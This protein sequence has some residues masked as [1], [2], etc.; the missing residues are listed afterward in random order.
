VLAEA[1]LERI[2]ARLGR[3]VPRLSDEA[4]AV[5]RAHRWPGNVRELLNVLERAVVL[6]EGDTI[7][8]ADLPLEVREVE[9]ETPPT[10][11]EVLTIREAEKRAIAA[12]LAATGGRKG[13]AAAL[14][15]ISW[16]TLNRK[17]REYGLPDGTNRSARG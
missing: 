17:I 5:L 3:R 16:P 2:G 8:P 15:G 14:L 6:L 10:A 11:A 13:A 1:M 4:R 12:A 9:G 7:G